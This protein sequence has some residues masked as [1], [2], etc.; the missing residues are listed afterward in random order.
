MVL[1]ELTVATAYC[2]GLKR[3]YR[4]A[5]KIQRRLISSKHIKIRQFV[6]RRTRAA[7]DVALKVHQNIQQRDI[8]AGRN[9]GNWILRWLDRIK[10]SANISGVR[11]EKPP[12][13]H[14]NVNSSMEKQT[15]ENQQKTLGSFRRSITG[16]S[17]QG[18]DRQMF[19]TAT[20]TWAK[21][22]PTIAVV[23][24]PAKPTGA[25]TQFR[26]FCINVPEVQRPSDGRRHGFEGEQITNSNHPCEKRE[27]SDWQSKLTIA[28]EPGKIWKIFVA[29]LKFSEYIEMELADRAV[30][31]LL[32]CVSLSIFTYYTFWVIILPFV[33]SD[34]FIHKYF[35]PQEYAILIPVFGGVALLCFL[36]IFIGLVML[37]SKK[38]KA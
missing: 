34:H 27:G 10:P 33:D 2:L 38:K 29:Y 4:L 14:N 24:R 3:T 28:G 25:A 19:S 32:S 21:S 1:W 13:I 12:P 5:L 8:E 36:S 9:L 37:K 18:S 26:H 30:G 15:A 6:Q 11:P 35:L 23:L 31:F 22:F 16:S 17:N 20:H 7:F